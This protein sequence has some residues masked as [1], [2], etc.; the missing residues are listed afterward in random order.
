MQHR[1][2]LKELPSLLWEQ[3]ERVRKIHFPKESAEIQPFEK[4][5]AAN[6]IHVL[7]KKAESVNAT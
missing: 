2:I 5:Q 6:I 4:N 3:M 7:L 1:V